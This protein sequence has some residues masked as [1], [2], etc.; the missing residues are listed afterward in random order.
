MS[1][2][3]LVF[4][5]TLCV[6]ACESGKSERGKAHY[7]QRDERASRPHITAFVLLPFIGGRPRA[8]EDYALTVMPENQPAAL[9]STPQFPGRNASSAT[10]TKGRADDGSRQTHDTDN[11]RG[12]DGIGRRATRICSTF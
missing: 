7:R 2:E 5:G 3:C 8:K 1:G 6:L 12:R 11:G 10:K 9:R 4:V